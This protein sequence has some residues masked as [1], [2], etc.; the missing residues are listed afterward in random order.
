MLRST[1]LAYYEN[2]KEYQLLQTIDLRNVHTI[3]EVRVKRPFVIGLVTPE[4]TYYLQAASQKEMME[5]ITA[6]KVARREI[7]RRYASH[8]PVLRSVSAP[9]SPGTAENTLPAFLSSSQLDTDVAP[10][11]PPLGVS[12]SASSNSIG[13]DTS[14]APRKV[15]FT[16]Q[17]FRQALGAL[18]SWGSA[19]GSSL[20]LAAS[21][22]S[23]PVSIPRQPQGLPVSPSSP[24]DALSLP[25]SPEL[26]YR[27]YG[28]S[29]DEDPIGSDDDMRLSPSG[30]VPVPA[31]ISDVPPLDD[32][33]EEIIVGPPL[34]GEDTDGVVYEG[35]LWKLGRSGN[36][37]KRRWFVVRGG[38]VVAYKD[39]KVGKPTKREFHGVLMLDHF[40]SRSTNHCGLF[41]F[42][43]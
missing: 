4:R 22:S 21:S 36:G 38:K 3:A 28:P 1:R 26:G 25:S 13:K 14:R 34:P 29:S 10:S 9:V 17:P 41:R 6:I 43:P 42:R 12:R 7:R 11:Q 39:E 23:A 40:I 5:W 35:W 37:W 24:S 31:P 20:S 30:P 16:E 8:Q 15:S 2:E 33:S 18:Q 32:E 27:S 19:V